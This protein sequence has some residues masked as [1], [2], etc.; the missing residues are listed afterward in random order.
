MAAPGISCETYPRL[1][2]LAATMHSTHHATESDCSS[3]YDAEDLLAHIAMR[4]ATPDVHLEL[5]PEFP[6]EC[7]PEPLPDED[8]HEGYAIA[9]VLVLAMSIALL[10]GVSLVL[11]FGG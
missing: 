1:G 8:L 5:L 7:E 3:L 4:A 11:L 6:V 10:G 9:I 2:A